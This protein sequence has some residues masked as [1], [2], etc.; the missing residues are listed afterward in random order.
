MQYASN[1]AQNTGNYAENAGNS[2][3][4]VGDFLDKRSNDYVW[5]VI[6]SFLS[7]SSLFLYA[8]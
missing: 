1:F 6:Q 3:Q 4:Y 8:S 2:I 7:F 5:P